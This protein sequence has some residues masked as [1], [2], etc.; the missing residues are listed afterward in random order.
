MDTMQYE[1]FKVSDS[2]IA[3]SSGHVKTVRPNLALLN[4]IIAC[5]SMH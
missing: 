4:G 1:T 5:F 3:T 2:R